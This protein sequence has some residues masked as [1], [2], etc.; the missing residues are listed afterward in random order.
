MKLDDWFR[1]ARY[2]QSTLQVP[3]GEWVELVP[4]NPYR[5]SLLVIGATI[6]GFL[7]FSLDQTT[8]G[9]GMGIYTDV[10]AG[11]L[12]LVFP[13]DG[14]MVGQQWFVS[15]SGSGGQEARIVQQIIDRSPCDK[16]GGVSVN[17]YPV[18]RERKARNGLILPTIYQFDN[19]G[20]SV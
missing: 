19:G 13:N 20:D 17:P 4:S 5:V 15:T 10:L 1:V 2:Q 6:D 8:F 16:D 18:T 3:F 7:T 9:P 11:K 14:P 12:H